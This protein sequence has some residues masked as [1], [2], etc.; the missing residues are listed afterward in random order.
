MERE[1]KLTCNTCVH[2]W[3]VVIR[4]QGKISGVSNE[5]PL[6]CHPQKVGL[7]FPKADMENKFRLQG[8]YDSNVWINPRHQNLFLACSINFSS[9]TFLYS[10]LPWLAKSKT[11]VRTD[12]RAKVKLMKKQLPQSLN[13]HVFTVLVCANKSQPNLIYFFYWKTGHWIANHIY[14]VQ[15]RLGTTA[16]PGNW[17][18]ISSYAGHGMLRIP[19]RGCCS[20]YVSPETSL[21]RETLY[22][23]AKW[24]SLPWW[25]RKTPDNSKHFGEDPRGT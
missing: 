14:S 18:Q 8:I 25:P 22:S 1:F 11:S 6:C 19:T 21:Q 20:W 5:T 12:W 15:I 16:S 4:R 10:F 13:G 9:D 23:P 24:S 17:P 2:T 7:P 3:L